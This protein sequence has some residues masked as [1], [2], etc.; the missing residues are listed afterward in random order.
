MMH[1]KRFNLTEQEQLE[2][3]QQKNRMMLEKERVF[4]SEPWQ[5]Y[6]DNADHPLFT[7][8]VTVDKPVASCYYCSK[9]W[10]WRNKHG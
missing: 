8:K 7:I 2:L 5:G 1:R 10:I 4:I 6:C 3:R 9:T